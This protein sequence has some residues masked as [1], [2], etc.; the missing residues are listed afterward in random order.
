MSNSLSWKKFR[1]NQKKVYNNCKG[2]GYN[3]DLTSLKQLDT[4]ISGIHHVS[5]LIQLLEN[6]YELH[7][8][9]YNDNDIKLN[10]FIEKIKE[11]F[12]DYD[13]FNWEKYI[14]NYVDLQNAG[15]DDKK[16]AWNHWY[17][18]GKNENRSFI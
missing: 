13:N 10:P 11:L 8:T 4:N 17:N 1:T 5:K 7:T 2:L 16:K 18:H 15:I 3:I 14:N 12:F 6:N 9:N